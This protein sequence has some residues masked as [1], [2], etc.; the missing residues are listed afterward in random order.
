MGGARGKGCAAL[1]AALMTLAAGTVTAS[2]KAWEPEPA[3]YGVGSQM[4]V[5]VTMKDGTVLSADVYF[6]TESSGAAA[7]GPFPVIM[8]QNPYAKNAS[9]YASGREGGGEGSTEIGEGPYLVQRGYI[10][11]VADV[12]GTG[13]SGGSFQIL[14]PQ[15]GKDGAELVHW[16]AK[17]PN[18]NGRVGLY[19][20]SYMGL[21]Q[22]MTAHALA[23]EG[24]DSPLKALFPIVTAN[25]VYRDLAFMGGMPGAAFDVVFVG[26]MTA[27]ET[28][29]P[30]ATNYRDPQRGAQVTAEH[31]PG[32]AD[33]QV[34]T[35]ADIESGGPT[36]YDEDFWQVRSIRG[37]L[38]DAVKLGVPA[39]MVGG[40]YD[41]FQRGEPLNYSGLQNAFEHRDVA[42]PM[43]PDQHATG[44]YQLLQGPWY[45]LD[46]GTGLDIYRLQLAWYDRWLKDE[47]TGIDRTDSPL[48]FYV[49]GAK[50]WVEAA[51]YP[52]AE[53][54][55]RTYYLG[56]G[57]TLA[58]SAPTDASAADQLVY[59]GNAGSPC[60][61]QADQWGAGGEA[62]AF[63]YAGQPSPC[64]RDDRTQQV[65]PGALTYTTPAFTK[66]E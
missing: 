13:G 12:R 56:A 16:A 27:V 6:P 3:S 35:T 24:G 57:N 25:D 4:N 41:V 2:A 50:K 49:L 43:R 39:F 53:A 5:P 19:G 7:K 30:W 47:D 54:T 28:G 45:H 55:P 23:A 8:V 61:R 63:D 44:R 10:D 48:H 14:D 32:I 40:W 64:D 15:Q 46:A 52:F 31:A 51:R 33:F 34:G 17:L 59:T 37:M 20:P 38:G 66:D 9:G 26:L 18:S 1:L 62:L 36:A 42:A 58:T 21:D 60:G 65:G 11:V 29:G 22:F